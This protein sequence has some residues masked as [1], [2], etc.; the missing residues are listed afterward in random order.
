MTEEAA[1][2]EAA[3]DNPDPGCHAQTADEFETGN[4]TGEQVRAGDRA[5]GDVGRGERGRYDRDPGMQDRRVVR[6]VVV[7]R[8]R[9]DPVEP[10]GV[11][12]RSEE[13]TSELPVTNAHLV[14]R[15]LLEKKKNKNL[16]IHKHITMKHENK[17]IH[18]TTRD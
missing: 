3:L 5:P 12:G 11:M 13:H 15:L 1:V 10:R 18:K 6:V 2:D 16:V 9:H 7:A 17:L 4:K 8:M 14:C